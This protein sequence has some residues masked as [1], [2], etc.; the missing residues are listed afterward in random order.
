M[1]YAPGIQPRGDQYLFAGISQLG[2]GLGKS[3]QNFVQAKRESEFLDKQVVSL[4]AAMKPLIEAGDIQ[5]EV[6]Q[7]M[8]KFPGM[9]LSQKRG[10]AASMVFALQSA[11]ESKQ[12]AQAAEDRTFNRSVQ[13][14]RLVMEAERLNRDAQDR[15]R[16]QAGREQFNVGLSEYLDTPEMLRR[17]AAE[18]IP[19]IAARA[20]VADPEMAARMADARLRE[21]DLRIRERAV[22]VQEGNLRAREEAASKPPARKLSSTEVKLLNDLKNQR[23]RFA[24]DVAS[25][26][27]EL[28]RGNKRSGPDWWWGEKFQERL[29]AART[30]LAETEQRIAELEAPTAPTAAA[31]AEKPQEK[32]AEKPAAARRDEAPDAELSAALEAIQAGADPAKVEALYKQRTG[33]ALPW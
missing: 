3:I 19:S 28:G 18:A 7:E 14:S 32:P 16:T 13:S 11:K 15:A 12:E 24:Q 4:A 5:P 21:A 6:V 29:D 23:S 33:K 30:R 22:G 27:A 9:S 31:P 25:A 10:A 20:G 2:E 26:E 8:E 1:P 17:P